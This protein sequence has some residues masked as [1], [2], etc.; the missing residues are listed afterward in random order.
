MSPR[1]TLTEL[2]AGSTTH[3]LRKHAVR[4]G[5]CRAARLAGDRRR[6]VSSARQVRSVAMKAAVLETVP[7]ELV[8]DDVQTRQS[9]PR[10]VLVRTVAAGLCHSDL[11]FMEGMYPCPVPDGARARVGRRGRGRR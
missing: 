1:G 8:I 9:G 4:P 2:I 11:H 10:E 6:T 5:C 3:D 7:G